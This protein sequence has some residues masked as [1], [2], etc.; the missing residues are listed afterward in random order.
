L[1]WPST[2]KSTKMWF[3][4]CPSLPAGTILRWSFLADFPGPHQ[5][6]SLEYG[7]IQ[8]RVG[9]VADPLDPGRHGSI[10]APDYWIIGFGVHA[11]TVDGGALCRMFNRAIRGQR[12]MPRYLSSDNDPLYRLHQ[13]Q[14]NLRVLEVT[15][16]KCIPYVP[17][18]HPSV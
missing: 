6:Q 15:N 8:V 13:W 9:H 14:A 3:E 10:F 2:S 16:S 4:G 12:R 18:S 17:L 11:G 7:S 5:R 1:P